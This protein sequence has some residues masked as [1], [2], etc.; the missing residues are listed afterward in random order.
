M[1][2]PPTLLQPSAQL[3]EGWGPGGGVGRAREREGVLLPLRDAMYKSLSVIFYFFHFFFPLSSFFFHPL[4]LTHLYIHTSDAADANL[5]S[6]LLHFNYYELE[7][8]S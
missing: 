7:T 1:R 2:G 4:T 8:K 6:F 3:P 5:T